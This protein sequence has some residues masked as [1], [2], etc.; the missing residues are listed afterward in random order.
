MRRIVVLACGAVLAFGVWAE[1]GEPAGGDRP[2][3][4]GN[5]IGISDEVLPP[6][7]PVEAS[8]DKA[9][10]WGRTYRFG[11]LPL[12]VSV[13]TRGQEVLAAPVTLAGQIAGKAISWSGSPAVVAEVK[14]HQA[15]FRAS[16]T[17][18]PLRCEGEVQVEYDGMVRCDF[19]LVPQDRVAIQSLA[20]EIP[21]KA[22]HAQFLHT[23]P[24]RWGSAANSGAVASEGHRG[25][26]KPFVWLGDHWRGLSW[27]AECD[28]NFFPESPD[29]VLDIRREGDVVRWRVVLVGKP[30]TIDKPLEYTFGFHATP[31]KPA[32]PDAWDW[33]IVHMGNYG[34]DQEVYAP[35]GA[36]SKAD[37]RKPGR[38]KLLLDHLAECGVRTICF[39]EHWSDIQNY[40]RASQPEALSRLAT[41]CHQ[42][43]IQLLLYFGYEMS[44]IAPEWP[45]YGEECLVAP[46]AG[47][48]KRK[49]EQTAYIVCYRSHWQDF[50]AEGI[51]RTLAQHGVD[52]V[53]LDGTSEPWGC[54]NQRHGCGYRRPDGSIGP[55]YPF[56]AT[57]QM[58]KRIYTIVKH[59]NPDGQVNVHQSTCMTIPTLAFAT[60]YW[61]GEQL[62]SV[63][64]KPSA[65]ALLPLDAFCAE[66]MGHNWGV[67]AELLWYGSGPFR[68]EE[69]VSLALLHDV[70]VRPSGLVDLEHSRRLW[71]MFDALGRRQAQ[72]IPY[73]QSA[74]VVKTKPA[75]VRVSL[76]HRPGR[77]VVAVLVNLGTEA[78]QAEAVFDLQA[79]GQSGRWTA[80][81]VLAEKPIALSDSRLRLPLGPLGHA[82]V[83]LR[84]EK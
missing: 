48:Y 83:W 74:P 28:R 65:L 62:Q 2:P 19:R 20:L 66:F 25:P 50:L 41:A 63:G 8:G 52:G 79:L 81:D 70:P 75:E 32:Q 55:T 39:H 3:W 24:G 59:R 77:G 58:M 16:A 23:W 18:G 45:R 40:P 35:A 29:R 47:G 17:A 54:T 5:R 42:R 49:P 34:L 14:P 22:Q 68:R 36:G 76:Y 82:V 38:A 56:F 21:L 37:P 53:Y 9:T 26:F 44:N 84:P 12:P 4:Q 10:V 30:Q 57:R 7:T 72:W 43:H 51:D 61:D 60:S 13:V 11:P 6:W 80:T 78:C 73:W 64:R 46:R 67:P 69:A 1:S 31:V 71:R 33:R 27:F 15:R